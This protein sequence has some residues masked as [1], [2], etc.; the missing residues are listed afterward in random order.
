VT[1]RDGSP[2]RPLLSDQVLLALELL[3]APRTHARGERLSLGRRLEQG[4]R[5]G[6]GDASGGHA[7]SLG[8]ARVAKVRAVKSGSSSEMQRAGR[9]GRACPRSAITSTTKPVIPRRVA[10]T[11]PTGRRRLGGVEERSVAHDHQPSEDIQPSED[12]KAE[13]AEAAERDLQASSALFMTGLERATELERRKVH[14]APGDEARDGLAREIEAIT[15][16]LVSRGRYQTRLIQL[17]EQALDGQPEVRHPS[18]VLEDWRAAERRLSEA[19][20]ELERASDEADRLR[21][22]HRHAFG[23]RR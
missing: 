11:R 1:T 6:A 14:L 10:V 15:L 23:R 2:Q 17:E 19:R 5:T 22:E 21:E 3:E 13:T 4:F 7:G 18:D 20:I 8:R 16:D 9:Y 12:V